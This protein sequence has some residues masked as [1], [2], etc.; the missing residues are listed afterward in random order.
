LLLRLRATR[1]L[2]V[3]FACALACALPI[4]PVDAAP[5]Q[6]APSAPENLRCHGRPAPIPPGPDWQVLPVWEWRDVIAVDGVIGSGEG[7]YAV[8]V[9]GGCNIYLT[10]TT[11]FQILKLAPDGAVTARWPLPGEHSAGQSGS[12]RGVAVDSRGNVYVTDSP[13]DRVYK[14]SPQGQVIAT[15]GVCESPSA[16]NGYCDAKRPGR[17]ISPEGI[18]VD[19]ADNVFVAE[20]AGGRVQKFSSEGKSLAKWD[21]KSRVPGDF[22][23][24]GSLAV[25]QGG[26]LYMAEAYNDQIVK[27]DPASG[28][29]IGRGG[30]SRGREPGQYHKPLG[31]GVDADG[32]LNVS[33]H[34]N[35]RVAKVAPDG[36]VLDQWR[37][38]LDADPPC[39]N[40]DGGQ[41]PGQFFAARGITVDGQG[42][43]YVADT[44]N[45]RL[46]RLMIVDFILVPPPP[47]PDE[48]A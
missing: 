35:W 18:A 30:G 3:A 28:A 41:A 44:Y 14:F 17:F 46:Q 20:G 8:A 39:Q 45:K 9:D 33:D 21:L 13:H 22:F 25:D 7:P 5:G 11:H 31:V 32:N 10:D 4:L 38:C 19:G 23:I 43:V 27:F 42:T 48:E 16:D 37:L 15:W 36:A 24:P 47:P 29:I 6:V 34:D 12:P 2:L 26:F 1:P 40:P